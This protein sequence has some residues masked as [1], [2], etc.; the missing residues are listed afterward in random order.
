MFD[1][2]VKNKY[3]K[4]IIKICISSAFIY[5][6]V[7][8][9][10]LRI[11]WENIKN[12][13]IMYFVVAFVLMLLCNLVGGISLHAL[14][15]NES[16]LQIFII[17]LKS[18]VYSLILPGQLFGESSKIFMLSPKTGKLSQRVS[19][20][21]VDKILN[22][23]ALLWLG[24]FGSFLS[25]N[26]NGGFIKW[27]LG[28]TSVMV[29][30][31]FIIGTNSNFCLGIYNLIKKL[32]FVKVRNCIGKFMEI[33]MI[34][35]N[36]KKAIMVSMVCGLLYH[37]LINCVYCLLAIG[38]HI[39][40]LFLDFYWINCLSTLILL[41][42]I[43]IGGLGIREAS[44]VG[45]LGLLG[46]K[47]DIAFSFS[48]LVLMLQVMRAFIGGLLILFDNVKWGKSDGL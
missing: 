7:N 28:V 45:M 25:A 15:N 44:L 46:I 22:L 10:D 19:A 18:S 34:Y 2:I 23:F 43:S 8:K 9:C 3:L 4:S 11:F 33:W 21:L 14:Y 6:L 30:V 17:T 41:L 31:F 1:K 32:P 37:L 38:L 29:T 26:L 48:I 20:V 39:D 24:T 27:L 40:I 35:V 47:E 5:Y 12:Y 42:P 13:P 16:I 36:N